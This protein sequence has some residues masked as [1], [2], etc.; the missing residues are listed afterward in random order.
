M[1]DMSDFEKQITRDYRLTTANIFYRLPD[2][3]ALLQ[4]FIWQEYDIAP[5]FPELMDF[6]DFWENKIEGS[7]HSVYVASRKIVAPATYESCN[8]DITIQ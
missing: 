2:H 7:I 4:E 5:R 3:P 1:R 6:L 8:F